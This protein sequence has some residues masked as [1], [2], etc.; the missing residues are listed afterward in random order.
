MVACTVVSS[1]NS[2]RIAPFAQTETAEE[3]LL[4]E[5]TS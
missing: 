2:A 5:E 3:D 1:Q 4:V